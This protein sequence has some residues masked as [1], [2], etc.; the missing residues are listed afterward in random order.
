[1]K[2]LSLILAVI[3][4]LVCIVP[5]MAEQQYFNAATTTALTDPTTFTKPYEVNEVIDRKSTRLN[6]SH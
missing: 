1:M 5:A 4:A 2:K 6:S 3:M